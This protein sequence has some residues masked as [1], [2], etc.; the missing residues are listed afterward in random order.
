[1]VVILGP[2]ADASIGDL[3]DA[4]GNGEVSALDALLIINFIGVEDPPQRGHGLGHAKPGVYHSGLAAGRGRQL[5][6]GR[7][8]QAVVN[9]M[10][11]DPNVELVAMG[12]IFEDKLEGSLRKLRDPKYVEANLLRFEPGLVVEVSR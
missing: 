1:M 6:G 2:V 4:N 7:G 11:A 8:T 12:D 5:C 9:L 3:F 10:H